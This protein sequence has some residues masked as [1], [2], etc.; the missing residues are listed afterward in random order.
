MAVYVVFSADG[1]V[2]NLKGKLGGK[3]TRV[4]LGIPIQKFEHVLW[5]SDW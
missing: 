1:K 4:Y 2:D 5:V 3:K